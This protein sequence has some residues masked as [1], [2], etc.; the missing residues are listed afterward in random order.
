MVIL[1][2]KTTNTSR[3]CF[4]QRDLSN[5]SDGSLFINSNWLLGASRA[6]GTTKY[7]FTDNL[8]EILITANGNGNNIYLDGILAHTCDTDSSTFFNQGAVL[9]SA[10]DSG[11]DHELDVVEVRLYDT[12]QIA[13]TSSHGSAVESS[14]FAT[15][16]DSVGGGG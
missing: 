14:G 2:K 15:I 4:L 10:D 3:A 8:H 6:Y 12:D 1:F 5:T 7:S 9:L 13:P 11:E 16:T